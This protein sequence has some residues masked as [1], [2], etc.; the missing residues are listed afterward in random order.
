MQMD[1]IE[2]RRRAAGGFLPAPIAREMLASGVKLQDLLPLARALAIPPV[3][4]FYVGVVVEGASGAIYFGAN[5]E[6]AGQSLA[7][8]VHAEQAA[9]TMAV[10]NG[11]R[12][13][14]KLAV[15]AAPC[16]LCRQF[17]NEL[18]TA[19]TLEIH[20]VD[21]E[22]TTLA[23]L[24]PHSFGPADLGIGAGLCS[25]QSHG[26]TLESDDEL[27]LAALAA[28]NASYAPYS[29]SFAGV[30]LRTADAIYTGSLAENAAFNP[31]MGPMEAALVNLVIGGGET[32]AAISDAVLVETGSVSQ[33]DASRAVLGTIGK[34]ELR[35]IRR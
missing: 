27:A 13:I 29:R 24:L 32:Y 34:V 6:F 7:Y 9:V 15:T 26:L 17:L 22:P 4:E 30:A 19:S 33:A 12:G 16:G 10:A 8:T 25:P 28:A 11:E 2:A 31:S 21:R 35:G 23:A 18:T 5:F 14:T 3:S 1:E 20:V